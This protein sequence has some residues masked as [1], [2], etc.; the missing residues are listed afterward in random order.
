ML[1]YTIETYNSSTGV[2]NVGK[3]SKQ[4]NLIRKQQRRLHSDKIRLQRQPRQHVHA[5]SV[6]YE[7]INRSGTLMMILW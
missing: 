1:T 6:Q 7:W 4:A 3:G 2:R 5:L